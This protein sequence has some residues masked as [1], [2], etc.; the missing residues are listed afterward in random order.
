MDNTQM[1]LADDISRDTKQP[2]LVCAGRMVWVL[3]A[4]D[5]LRYPRLPLSW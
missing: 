5:A 3:F 1:L 4:A 2:D